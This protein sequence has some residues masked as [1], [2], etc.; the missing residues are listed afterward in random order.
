M[1]RNNDTA[2][3]ER[4][5]IAVTALSPVSRLWQEALQLLA[6]YQG[7]L[8][9]LFL[10]DTQWLRAASLPFTREISRLS[11]VDVDF[12]VQRAR[13]VHDEAV[14]RVRRELTQLAHEQRR[15]LAF[16]VLPE[17]DRQRIRDLAA[18]AGCIVIAPAALAQHGEFEEIEQLG[19]RLI[20]IRDQ[21]RPGSLS[22]TDPASN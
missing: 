7:E 16:E 17:T 20:L 11:G 21:D 1:T 18:G 13:D 4:I 9:A 10:E 5:V 14:R 2:R 15:D 8:H 12:T 19:C 3:V 22:R 6:H